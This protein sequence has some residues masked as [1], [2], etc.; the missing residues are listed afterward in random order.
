[1]NLTLVESNSPYAFIECE[2]EITQDSTFADPLR[3]QFGADI[4]TRKVAFDLEGTTRIDSSGVSWFLRCQKRFRENQG[5]LT[6]CAVPLA[7]MD[8]LRV[9]S[10]DEIFVIEDRAELE[11]LTEEGTEE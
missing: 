11:K 5:S 6:L 10:L 1:M 8:V 9:L 7:V 3:D 4:Y 2:G